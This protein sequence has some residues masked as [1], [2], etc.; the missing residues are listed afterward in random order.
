MLSRLTPAQRRRELQ[1]LNNKARSLPQGEGHREE[2][3]SRIWLGGL[4]KIVSKGLNKKQKCNMG[5]L[6]HNISEED[7]NESAQNHSPCH[8]HQSQIPRPEPLPGPPHLLRHKT[9]QPRTA[10]NHPRPAAARVL[11]S[12]HSSVLQKNKYHS[13]RRGQQIRSSE[14]NDR[15]KKGVFL[16]RSR[17]SYSSFSSVRDLRACK[18][19]KR[20]CPAP[21]VSPLRPVY[22]ITKLYPFI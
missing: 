7:H 6:N 8:L 17:R 14:V 19:K 13:K 11:F 5:D 10:S 20:G 15:C 21:V 12:D 4:L 3:G 16:T 2:R 18:K 22:T 9:L 1:R